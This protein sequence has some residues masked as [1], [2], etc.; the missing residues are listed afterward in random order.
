MSFSSIELFAG[1]GGLALGLEKAGF[2]AVLLNELDKHACA[3]LRHNRPH[4]NVIEGSIQTV[5]FTPYRDKVDFVSGGFPCQAFSYAG[6]KRGFDDV[7]GTLF[8]EFARAIQEI[9]PKVF[10]AENV[11]GLLNHDEGRTLATIEAVIAD[12]GYTLIASSVLKAMFYRV[13]QKRERLFLVG[14]RNDL[15]NNVDFSFPKPYKRFMTLKDALK[16][17]ELYNCDVPESAGQTYPAKKKA[18]LDLVPAGGYWRNLPDDIQRAYMKKSYFLGGGKTGM[19]RRLS[20]EEPSLTLTCAPA[21]NQTERCHPDETRPLT[22]REYARIQTFPDNWE[23]MGAMS[24]QYK[25]IGNAVPVNLAY[26]VGNSLIDLLNSLN[27]PMEKNEVV[28]SHAALKYW[29]SPQQTNI[30]G[31]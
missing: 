11:R 7:R 27:K 9:Q 23:F 28:Q 4:W 18:V 6:N 10:L 12:L 31:F 24:A 5:D 25:Q 22:V 2:E 21:Q 30:P 20:W 3:T 13:P 8:F 16:A 26:A 15:A 19:A 29:A 14:V 1:A 17:G